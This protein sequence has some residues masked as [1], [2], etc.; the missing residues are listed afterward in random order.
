MKFV[1][2]ILT[3]AFAA[4]VSHAALYTNTVSTD[5]FVRSNAPASNY[6]AAGALS[7][8]GSSATNAVG[9]VNGIADS[10][11]RFNTAGIVTSL[12]SLFGAG[13]WVING[14][15][16]RVVEV[17]VPNNNIFTR[18]KGAFEI[19]WISN[20]SWTEGTGMPM[21]PTTDGIAYN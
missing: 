8:S 10:F 18:G 13:N 6:G 14:A 19:R 2:A 21:G 3:V 17:G 9:T 5:A 7:V 1:L 11:I 12:D 20:D 16:L 4:A 15:A